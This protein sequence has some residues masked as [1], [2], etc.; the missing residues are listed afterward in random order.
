L[1]NFAA[2]YG[3]VY[4]TE[5]ILPSGIVSLLWGVFPMMMALA[6]HLYLPQERLGRVHWLGFLFGLGGVGLLFFTDLQT[7]GPKGAPAALLLFLSPLVS[8]ISNTLVKKHGEN[9]SSLALNRNAMLLGGG[10]LGALAW[11]TERHAQPRWTPGAILSVGYLALFGTVLTFGLYFW[12]MRY[13]EAHKIGL[14]SYVTPVI[15][16]LLGTLVRG[17]PLTQN[18]VGGATCILCGVFLVVRG[19]R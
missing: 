16:L 18:T 17:E 5:T 13:I 14:I 10:V 4:H 2:S 12:L 11:L 9:T 8:A 15:A 3:I 6:A 1:T 19:R 7:F